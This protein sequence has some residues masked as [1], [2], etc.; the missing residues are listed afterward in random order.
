MT[1]ASVKRP[2][3][4]VSQHKQY[5]QCPQQWYLQRKVRAWQRPAAWLAHGTAVHAAAEFWERSVRTASVADAQAEFARVY[6]A[7]LAEDM[8]ETPN[9]EY[10]FSSGPYG[11]AADIERRF[12]IGLEQVAKYIEYYTGKGKDEAIWITPDGTPAIELRFDI[13]LDGVSIIGYIDQ[14]VNGEARDIKTGQP[15]KDTF[16]LGT[17][18]VAL[19]EQWGLKSDQGSY[20]LAKF[21]RPVRTFDVTDWTKERVTDEFGRLHEDITAE[22]FDPVIGDHCQRCPVANACPFFAR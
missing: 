12:G 2:R 22:R 8:E 11:G 7:T 13:E 15:P 3:Y 16:Q 1:E 10:W 18:K 17:Y 5:R 14:V 9:L 20:W 19:E 6:A 4:S 21:A